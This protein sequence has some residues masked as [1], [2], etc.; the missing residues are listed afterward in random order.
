M[1]LGY[2]GIPYLTFTELGTHGR[3]HTVLS[4]RRAQS[5]GGE[6]EVSRPWQSRVLGWGSTELWEHR[7]AANQ[8]EVTEACQEEEMPQL[9]GVG[10]RRI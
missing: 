4:S 1:S 9:G 5:A 3:Q 7:K 2:S 6:R 10:P 8:P